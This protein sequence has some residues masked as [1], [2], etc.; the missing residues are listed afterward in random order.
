MKKGDYVLSYNPSVRKYLIG[1]I[2]SEY[3]Y[4]SNFGDLEVDG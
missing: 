4:N 1:D 3:Y 2:I